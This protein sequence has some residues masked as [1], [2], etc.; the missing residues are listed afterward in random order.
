MS[1]SYFYYGAGYF[2]CKLIGLLK[3]DELER[4]LVAS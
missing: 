1:W 4:C 2:Y 3:A